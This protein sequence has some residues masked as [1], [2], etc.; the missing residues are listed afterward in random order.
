MIVE[1]YVQNHS[2]V[3]DKMHLYSGYVSEAKCRAGIA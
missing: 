2:A 3:T 1:N